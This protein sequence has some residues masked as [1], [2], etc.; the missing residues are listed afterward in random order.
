MNDN[1][2]RE[3]PL[4]E[5]KKLNKQIKTQIQ[6]INKPAPPNPVSTPIAKSPS[7]SLIQQRVLLKDPSNT[8]QTSTPI[9]PNT[10]NLN[11]NTSINCS[12][13]TIEQNSAQITNSKSIE[14]IYRSKKNCSNEQTNCKETK[15]EED[16][17]S[18]NC[19]NSIDNLKNNQLANKQLDNDKN[20]SSSARNN[21]QSD[22]G[23]NN[24]NENNEKKS[25]SSMSSTLSLSSSVNTSS[26]CS[27]SQQ[28]LQITHKTEDKIDPE[29][30]MLNQEVK[31]SRDSKNFSKENSPSI[32]SFSQSYNLNPDLLT[33]NVNCLN[34]NN[35][36]T[37]RY[38]QFERRKNSSNY[39]N[40]EIYDFSSRINNLRFIDDSAS[41]TALTSPAESLSRLY[42]GSANSLNKQQQFQHRFLNNYCS[43][44]QNG[45]GGSSSTSSSRT[46]SIPAS[47]NCSVSNSTTS[48]PNRSNRSNRL[49]QIQRQSNVKSS[50]DTLCSNS[51]ITNDCKMKSP[52]ST[53]SPI[54]MKP[55]KDQQTITDLNK[56]K[57]PSLLT[58]SQQ[59]QH[60]NL[61]DNYRIVH[62]NHNNKTQ[63]AMV[64]GEDDEEIKSIIMN[65]LNE[66][67]KH[68]VNKQ[69][70]QR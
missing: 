55:L 39:S 68:N 57:L 24:L 23:I 52:L 35:T 21:K 44:N 66:K 50:T 10:S 12:I 59:F 56:A 47:S 14:S 63:I 34:Q 51:S 58:T 31:T 11:I 16:N 13:T 43:N 5:N 2:S 70:V 60:E 8:Q 61:T 65:N 3:T 49:I 45:I 30:K 19:Y 7:N 17:L 27:S 42:F 67:L 38:H 53:S 9:N 32:C 4:A 22:I 62:N 1:Y 33:I 25:T 37:N 40:E 6:S 46:V 26:S 36:I 48:T 69:H 18:S 54:D 28:L 41:S 29:T 20:E 15:N 64:D